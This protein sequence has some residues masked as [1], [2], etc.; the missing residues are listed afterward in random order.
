[1]Q[2]KYEDDFELWARE[3]VRIVD[4]LTGAEVPFVLNAPQRRVLSLL[5]EKR[6]L[7]K[8]VRVIM[9]KARQWGGSTLMQIYMAWMQL[10][11]R[12]GWNSLT[13][14]H[15]RDASTAIRG[16]YSR[17]LR[18][19]P[20]DMKE[21]PSKDW[22]LAP[23]EKSQT[24]AYVAARDAQVAVATALSPN[25]LR[26]YSMSMAHLSEVAFWADGDPRRAEEIVRTVSGSIPSAPDTLI[27][28]ESTAN[29]RDNFFYHEW[30]R[31]VERKSDKTAIFVP[32]HEIEIYSRDV[33]PGERDSLLGSFDSY[34][35]ALLDSGVDIRKVAWYHDKR[36]EYPTHEAMMAEFPS[37]PEEAFSTSVQGLV[38]PRLRPR[39]MPSDESLSSDLAVVACLPA[40]KFV[41]SKFST[42]DGRL[43]CLSD[44]CVSDLQE[45]VRL[46]GPIAVADCGSDN[47][48]SASQRLVAALFDSGCDVL[49]LDEDEPLTLCRPVAMADLALRLEVLLREN[50]FVET[51]QTGAEQLAAV[52]LDNPAR[53]P[54]AVTRLLAARA[55]DNALC[56][57]LSFDDLFW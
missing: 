49:S 26:G 9:L 35:R 10:V 12:R 45:I 44:E 29:G 36:R 18:S 6:R 14:A 19:Y 42:A 24:V 48:P 30:R 51:S 37:T 39:P 46:K 41:V 43:V 3:C 7:R 54:L 16:M 13:C 47:D 17:L 5:E 27:V 21:G 2:Q 22:Q 20:Q 56:Q 8:P 28:M 50:R 31:A 1:M 11:V 25:S 33:A 32:W 52:R 40:A 4:K 15:V 57:P 53:C 55:A 34:E 38:A 23:Y